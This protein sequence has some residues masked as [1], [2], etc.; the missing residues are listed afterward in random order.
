MKEIAT[1]VLIVGGGPGGYVAAIRAGQLGLPTVLVEKAAL[2]GTCLNVGCIPSK[3]LIHAAEQYH[4]AAAGA[5]AAFGLNLGSPALDF[6]RTIAWKDGIVGRLTGGVGGLLRRSKVSVLEGEAQ[7]EDGKTVIV[8][9][10][11]GRTRVRCEH[12]VIATG[13]VP[14][15]AP[16]LPFGGAVIDSTEALA[17][18][19][20]PASLA[21][22]GAGY[23]GIE[24]G[25]AF[26]K[27]GS[28]VT[29]VEVA[30]RIL[31][32]WDAELTKPVA[33]RLG[34][35]G[36]AVL[37]G[38]FADG[39]SADGRGLLVRQG[40]GGETAAIAAERI[41]VAVGRRAA[42]Q[43]FG[44][45]RLD[46]TMD[47]P[48]IAI[49]DRCATSMRDVWAVGDVTGEPML[50][51]RAMAQGDMVA[52]RIAGHR[53]SFE[54][55]AIPAIC[56]C[57]P[58]I[59]SVGLS[60]EQARAAGEDVSVGSFPFIANG[61]AMTQGDE[62]GFVRVVARTSDRVVLGIQAVGAGISELA[63]AF[64]LAIEMGAR[65]DDVAATI[66]AH[67]TRG[68]ALQEAALASFG[69]PVHA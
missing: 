57:D 22:V 34:E 1:R 63:A 36:V 45:E 6:G 27:L 62:A 14:A 17:L 4:Y 65:A 21:V 41:L 28:R 61:R 38:H 51:H 52:E 35:L 56:F 5:G 40:A 66:H 26:A 8:S 32:A 12:L 49:D 3:A 31:P 55:A 60:A 33:K 44:L 68:E 58:E 47:G 20:V 50:A 30:D 9:D 7:I 64:S 19:K 11:A 53:R 59:V 69:K 25:T 42:T 18:D 37:T 54:P 2:G 39:V 46:L 15:G 43:G 67:P 24:L 13:S 23:I 16:A 48:F 29:I 10:D